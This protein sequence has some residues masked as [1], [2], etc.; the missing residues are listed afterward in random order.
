MARTRPAT[1]PATQ[2]GLPLARASADTWGRPPSAHHKAGS[3]IAARWALY[4]GKADAGPDE[5]KRSAL[6][7][8]LWQHGPARWQPRKP[9]HG[10]RPGAGHGL[11]GQDSIALLEILAG[12]LLGRRRPGYLRVLHVNHHLRGEE[13]EADQ[14]LVE[15]IAGDWA[16]SRPSPT[17]PSRKRQGTCRRGR[18]RPGARQRWRR[19]AERVRSDSSGPTRPTI[20]PRTSSTGWGVTA[21]WLRCAACS[22]AIH[23]GSG[24]C[25]GQAGGDGPLL[26]R[27]RVGLRR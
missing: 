8:L 19:P 13:S 24:L 21:A 25:W 1:R 4:G 16:S 14:A 5:R 11:G 22:P 15:A 2:S 12:T 20:R 23:P 18:A 7:H 26:S 27:Q 10:G 9:P 17:V 3:T 6:G